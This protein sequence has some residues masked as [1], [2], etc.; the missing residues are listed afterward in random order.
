MSHVGLEL[1][2]LELCIGEAFT[3]ADALR[4]A[5]L[6]SASARASAVMKAGRLVVNE[7]GLAV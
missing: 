7:C 6:E 3:P 1:R 4:A 2:M 5:T